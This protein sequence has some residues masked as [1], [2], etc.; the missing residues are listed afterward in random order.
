MRDVEGLTAFTRGGPG[1]SVL[2]PAAPPAACDG[3]TEATR[4]KRVRVEGLG[5]GWKE[6]L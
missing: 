3:L 5:P 6:S 4:K 1:A 2:A